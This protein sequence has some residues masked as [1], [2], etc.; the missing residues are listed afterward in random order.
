MANLIGGKNLT[1][2]KRIVPYCVFTDPQVGGVG[3]TGEKEAR[4]RGYKL[5]IGQGSDVNRGAGVRTG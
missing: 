3:L 4:A 2:D 1:I 5:K